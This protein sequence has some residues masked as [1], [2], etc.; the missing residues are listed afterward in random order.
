MLTGRIIKSKFLFLLE[1][2]KLFRYAVNTRG[3]GVR[4]YRVTNKRRF[5]E[6]RLADCSFIVLSAHRKNMFSVAIPSSCAWAFASISSAGGDKSKRST[7]T[8]SGG[9]GV[10]ANAARWGEF[11]VEPEWQRAAGRW[12][13]FEEG[14]LTEMKA[15]LQ[16]DLKTAP[17]FLEVV[18]TRRMLR[19]L[20]CDGVRKTLLPSKAARLSYTIHWPFARHFGSRALVAP[21]PPVLAYM[22]YACT[23]VFWAVY[24]LF[25]GSS[26]PD[27]HAFSA[28]TYVPAS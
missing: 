5:N 25:H 11:F 24:V 10:R 15:E 17:P 21:P 12:T 2:N 4:E 7:S 16:N 9:G 1:I 14:L 13:R 22:S 6:N 23:A 26:P 18:G 27:R 28:Y 8:S 3:R 19:F 20:R